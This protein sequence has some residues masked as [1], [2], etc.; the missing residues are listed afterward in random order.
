MTVALRDELNV[1]N[2]DAATFD[3]PRAANA[4]FEMRVALADERLDVTADFIIHPHVHVEADRYD[5]DEREP[6]AE[7]EDRPTDVDY[8]ANDGGSF[9]ALATMDLIC[10][11]LPERA[12]S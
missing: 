9:L 10:H 12:S 1:V 2:D 11:A 8:A 6:D 7:L 4:D 3:Q 5:A